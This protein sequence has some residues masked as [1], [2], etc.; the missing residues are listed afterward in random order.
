MHIIKTIEMHGVTHIK[1]IKTTLYSLHYFYIQ[2][3]ASLVSKLNTSIY[4]MYI[5]WHYIVRLEI[6]NPC[7]YELVVTSITLMMTTFWPKHVACFVWEINLCLNWIYYTFTYIL[8]TTGMSPPHY[9]GPYCHYNPTNINFSFR[10][11]YWEHLH[12]LGGT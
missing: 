9:E 11:T 2:R 8:N 4:F 3:N 7:S 5:I 6:S 1:V 12:K 10:F